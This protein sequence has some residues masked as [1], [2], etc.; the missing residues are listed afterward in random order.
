MGIK[1]SR[2]GCWKI[3][4]QW[5]QH[6]NTEA[7]QNCTSY[8]HLVQKNYKGSSSQR[9]YSPISCNQYWSFHKP[10][11]TIYGIGKV[12]YETN[13]PVCHQESRTT[14]ISEHFKHGHNWGIHIDIS[15][16]AMPKSGGRKEVSLRYIEHINITDTKSICKTNMNEGIKKDWE[17]LYNKN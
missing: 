15:K 16:N 2:L 5:W 8:H 7:N 1:D 11:W 4:C 17:S 9:S 12:K 13:I 6:R 14:R 3:T 10:L